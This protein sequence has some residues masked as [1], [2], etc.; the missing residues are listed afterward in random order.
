M[1]D[2]AFGSRRLRGGCHCGAVRFE[3]EITGEAELIDCNCSMCA[4][5]GFLHLIVPKSAFRQLQG[6]D[7]LTSYRFN[8]GAANHLFCSV[9]GVKAFYYPRSHP[10]GVSVNWRC[11]DDQDR[12]ELPI[13]HF[14]GRNW[15]S[16]IDDLHRA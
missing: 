13:R 6:A 12:I 16:S 7:Q 14:D 2:R 15:E 5:T 4:K 10:D 8:T 3:V 9:C 1:S 11:I